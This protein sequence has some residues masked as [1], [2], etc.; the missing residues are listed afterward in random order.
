[1]AKLSKACKTGEPCDT[2][3][4]Y[5]AAIDWCSCECHSRDPFFPDHYTDAMKVKWHLDRYE[6]VKDKMS[7]LREQ[8][9]RGSISDLLRF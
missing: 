6:K 4:G 9:G 2:W 3:A 7:G 5:G 1:M 8:R